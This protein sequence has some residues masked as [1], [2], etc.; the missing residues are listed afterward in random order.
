MILWTKLLEAALKYPP[1][2]PSFKEKNFYY[3]PKYKTI[4]SPLFFREIF[5][6]EHSLLLAAIL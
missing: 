4:H 1:D 3:T 6:I 5:K 2:S